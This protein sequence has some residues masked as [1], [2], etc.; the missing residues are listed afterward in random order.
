MLV[1]KSSLDFTI[2]NSLAGFRSREERGSNPCSIVETMRL[3]ANGIRRLGF[4]P[5]ECGFESRQSFQITK[6]LWWNVYTLVLETSAGDGLEV[7]VLSGV[8]NRM[9]SWRNW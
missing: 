8:P 2:L 6:L 9:L 5:G 3:S 7:R 1:S 4:Q